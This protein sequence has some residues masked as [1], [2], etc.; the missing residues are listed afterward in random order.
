MA[1]S[2]DSKR[3]ATSSWEEFIRLWDVSSGICTQIFEGHTQFVT[4]V[5]FSSDSRLIASSSHD[6]SVRLWRVDDG[7]CIRTLKGNM[8]PTTSVAFSI[9]SM[10]VALA[11]SSD[12]SVSV[13]RLDNGQCIKRYTC[14]ANSVKSI[15]FAADLTLLACI[16]DFG[17]IILWQNEASQPI[18]EI[19]VS[20][21]PSHLEFEPGND[22]I[23]TDTGSICIHGRI[24]SDESTTH[25]PIPHS[26][27]YHMS[28]DRCWLM[29]Q[30]SKILWLPASYRARRSII[31]GSTVATTSTSGRLVIFRLPDREPL[32]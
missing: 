10:F 3:L 15:A 32:Q 18:Q 5:V 23:I 8:G 6:R 17:T 1:F 11:S 2:A 9:D 30:E 29:W 24:L 19:T 7:Q 21:S 25:A 27:G 12:G 13:W 14:N 22:H 26:C 4:A 20:A 31:L 16:S 28:G